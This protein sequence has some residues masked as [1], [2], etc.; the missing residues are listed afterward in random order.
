MIH[1][2]LHAHRQCALAIELERLAVRVHRAHPHAG[3]PAHHVVDA[4]H[5][6]TA[7]LAQRRLFRGPQQLGVHEHVQRVLVLGHVNHDDPFMYVDLG[8]CQTHARG[9]IHRF[10]HVGNQLAQPLI[11]RGHRP[12]DPLQAR[13]RVF[14]YRELAQG[15]SPTWNIVAKAVFFIVSRAG[16]GRYLRLITSG[17]E[18][19]IRPD[20]LRYQ[21]FGRTILRDPHPPPRPSA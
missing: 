10:G 11:E 12:R 21:G 2:V 16:V 17:R 18:A 15:K 6:K 19:D 13:V 1:L 14:D 4:G 5:R 3:R 7:L 20:P 8:R 9:R